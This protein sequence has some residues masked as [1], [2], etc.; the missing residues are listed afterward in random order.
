MKIS[1]LNSKKKLGK[2]HTKGQ[3]SVHFAFGTVKN[4]EFY[5]LT[6]LQKILKTV[7]K[8]PHYCTSVGVFPRNGLV[9]PASVTDKPD[10]MNRV[11]NQMNSGNLLVIDNDT[12][13]KF[14]HT[15]FEKYW[16]SAFKGSGF[17]RTRSGSTI[18]G[19]KKNGTH[20]Y[21][22]A[23]GDFNDF[24]TAMKIMEAICIVE[25]FYKVNIHKN[26]RAV[27]VTP[28]DVKLSELQQPIYED[29]TKPQ[30]VG[31]DK[32][33]V[34]L[35]KLPNNYENLMK[36]AE[37]IRVAEINKVMDKSLKLHKKWLKKNH[38][39][40]GLKKSELVRSLGDY[41][42]GFVS[43]TTRL[44]RGKKC[45][46]TVGDLLMGKIKGDMFNDVNEPD[47]GGWSQKAK[48]FGGMFHSQAHGGINYY[49]RL[50]DKW[51]VE[52]KKFL[53]S[54]LKKNVGIITE[55][56]DTVKAQVG[57]EKLRSYPK[58]I[59]SENKVNHNSKIVSAYTQV[60]GAT[61]WDGSIL[62]Y[63]MLAF[64]EK[65]SKTIDG[66]FVVLPSLKNPYLI[67]NTQNIAKH[68][69]SSYPILKDLDDKGVERP[70]DIKTTIAVIKSLLDMCSC[71]NYTDLTNVVQ[72]SLDDNEVGYKIVGSRLVKTV[73]LNKP[74]LN[75]L[76][77]KPKG[78][79]KI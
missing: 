67:G 53:K 55:D 48:W 11:A 77:T 26:G 5:D 57:N 40:V 39:V 4:M 13:A 59:D 27:L 35:N 70:V 41:S 33:F 56:L 50:T 79:K 45:V 74:T 46:G 38:K 22:I 19:K 73:G 36:K 17:V 2:V 52:N 61:F 65:H 9:V 78:Y 66:E 3:D 1:I 6:S 14:D 60:I 72:C 62:D 68:L 15:I 32:G 12:G 75:V 7:G 24:K 21:Y 51:V 37:R 44:F 29:D 58:L 20:D 47:Y 16:K 28:V 49:L 34:V 64:I 63:D 76:P 71:E 30:I 18:M 31:N 69:A 25:G 10:A 43:E 23:K 42:R 54:I 8:N